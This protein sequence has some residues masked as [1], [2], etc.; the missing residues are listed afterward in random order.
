MMQQIDRLQEKAKG[1]PDAPGV[2]LF[3]DKR[4]HVL[5]IGKA[6]SLKKRVGSYFVD[7]PGGPERFQIGPMIDQI[8]DLEFILTENELEALILE[9]N[10]IKNHRPRYNIVLKDDK[11]YPFLRLD[12]NDPF[13]WVQVVRRIKDDG[14][15]YYGPYVPSTAMWDVLALVNKTIPLR[16][17]RSI[18]GR[19]LCLE[20]HLG[21]CL[22]P[23]EGLIGRKEYGELVDQARLLLDGKDQELTKRLKERMHQ[24]AET[25]EFEQAAKYRDQIASL[26]QVFERQK[27][28]SPRGEDLD[29]FGLAHEGRE[30]Q[31]QLFLI[32]R[33]RLIGR[34]TFTFELGA[35]TP[36]GLLASL[37]KQF[38]VGARDIPKEILLSDLLEDASLIAAWLVSRANRHVELLVPQRGRKARL[39]Q[40]A[41]RNAQEALA[42]SLRSSKSRESALKELQEA[43]GLAGLPRRIE[44]YD[45][46]NIS[47]TLAVGSQVVW[48]DGKPKKSGY[49][50]YKI[51]TVEGPDDFA[52]MAEVLHRRLQKAQEMPLPDLV[53]LD[54]GRGQLNA[55]LGVA[56]KLGYDS[57]QMVSLAKEEELVFHPARPKPI[58]LPERS[59]ARQLLQQIRDESHRFAVTYHRA[60]RGKSGFRSLL[61]DIPGIGAKRRRALLSHFGSL[62]RL[63]E[64]SIEELRRTAGVSESLATTIHDV[65]GAVSA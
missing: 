17:C 35:E 1:L 7:S 19:K 58:A 16:K 12:P 28:I 65:L 53:L 10:L 34:E 45:I 8:A 47:G 51:N 14:A 52:M 41:Q 27:V 3:R 9:S 50:R 6:L 46:S 36:S 63:R 44:A 22:G 31:V 64:A 43:L 2:Y 23:C 30:A 5:Y 4:G 25:L 60:L 59:R 21:R 54:G 56:R 13:P 62:R 18:E 61:D 15:L 55:A 20:Y 32:R 48:E 26:R 33:G 42:L 24:A 57:L 29:V 40:M 49:R 38:Y 11:H 39:V 37:L